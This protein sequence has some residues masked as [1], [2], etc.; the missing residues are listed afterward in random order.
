MPFGL[1]PSVRLA[2]ACRMDKLICIGKNYLKHAQELGDAVPEEPIIFLKPPSTLREVSGRA[3]V[4]WPQGAHHEIELVLRLAK[5]GEDW[6]F[7]HYTFGLDMTLRD[8]QARQKK[9]GWPWERAKSFTDSAIVG[10]FHPLSSLEQALALPFTLK[11]NG[12][13]RQSGLGRDMRWKPDALLE[14]IATWLPLREGDLLFTGTPE[15]VGP[16][17]AGD[18]LEITGGDVRYTVWSLK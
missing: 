4:A 17:N 9:N 13:V 7:S 8:I 15:G 1:L 18:E 11:I 14:E 6:T 3:D 10:P 2:K 16:V 5:R 12:E